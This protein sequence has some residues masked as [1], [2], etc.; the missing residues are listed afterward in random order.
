MKFGIS[1]P[2]IP[3]VNRLNLYHIYQR[4]IWKRS[5]PHSV[6]TFRWRTCLVG[7]NTY[8][9]SL[10]VFPG[11]HSLCPTE[12]A[13]W[14][15]YLNILTERIYGYNACGNFSQK[16][17]KTCSQPTSLKYKDGSK[18]GGP[19]NSLGKA[20]TTQILLLTQGAQLINTFI[21][22]ATNTR[23]APAH[24]LNSTT[25]HCSPENLFRLTI[26]CL[27]HCPDDFKVGCSK[28]EPLGDGGQMLNEQKLQ[29]EYDL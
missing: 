21:E 10:W 11:V 15:K 24:P 7:I 19:W 8:T 28:T 13:T 2:N 18:N 6:E 12:V 1:L 27:S 4:H 22:L 9:L 16:G 14:I 26:P 5:R 3:K 29:R 17:C 20:I 23:E 25:H